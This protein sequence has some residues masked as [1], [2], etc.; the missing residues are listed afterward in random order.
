LARLGAIVA[1]SPLYE[2]APVGGPRQG[3][4]LNAVVVVDTALDAGT[5]LDGCLS[6]EHNRGRERRERWGPRTLDLDLLLFGDS[7]LDEQGLIVPHPRL[8]ER[9]FVLQPLLDAWP[10]AVL[11]GGPAVADLLDDVAD[12][13]MTRLADEQWWVPGDP[14]VILETP[15]V[16]ASPEEAAAIVSSLYGLEGAATPLEGERDRNFLF[17]SGERRF[18]LKI[19]NPAQDPVL[20][21]LQQAASEYLAAADPGLPVPRA[22]RTFG[23]S[24]V[25]RSEL[26]GTGVLVRMQSFLAG[27]RL[28]D[29]HST[30][31][32]RHSLAGLLARLDLALAGFSHRG[33]VRDDLWDLTQLPALRNR[34]G[35][36]PGDRRRVIEAVIDD[37]RDTVLPALEGVRRQFIHSDANAANLL[38]E[39][40]NPDQLVGIVD[41]GDLVEGP[42]VADL[43]IAAA[44]QCLGQT[45]PLTV[46][47]DL[48]SAYHRHLPLGREEIALVPALVA[49]RLVQS[50]TI[51]A[52]RA[53]LHP[54][55]RDYIL[56][57][58]EPAWDAL[59]RVLALEEG[60]LLREMDR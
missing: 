48:V 18:S 13:Q 38:T 24:L 29:G 23:G 35:H 30:N 22:V 8:G 41:F 56:I 1:V 2:T 47:A 4:Y 54:E 33:G 60:W 49:A 50:H 53:V 57:H 28:P 51:S 43:A 19:A 31:A 42:L 52:W 45:D 32:S 26:G 17:V 15:P 20:L 21:D 36:L 16:D 6:I 9:R 14:A 46:V 3:P 27:D 7:V 12:Q 59:V 40:G 39:A 58:A 37:F 11:P 10:Q 25:G 34:T 5:F 44:Y 55:N